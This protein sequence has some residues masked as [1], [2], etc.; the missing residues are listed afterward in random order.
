MKHSCL[1]GSKTLVLTGVVILSTICCRFTHAGGVSGGTIGSSLDPSQMGPMT[2]TLPTI[3]QPGIT[4]SLTGTNQLL[5]TITNAASFA[6]YELYYRP[7][8]DVAYPWRLSQVGVQGQ[9]NFV[10]GVN[11]D[12]MFYQV[13][14]G[15]DW[16]ADG[17]P[18]QSDADPLDSNVGELSVV[19][20][21]PAN[22]SFIQ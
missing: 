20:L 1:V 7:S 12:Y 17:I 6:N 4:A 8:L 15:S 13:C 5:V 14:V 11:Y 22:G 9:S 21:T 19:I 2:V 10:V 3:P 16:D 18:N